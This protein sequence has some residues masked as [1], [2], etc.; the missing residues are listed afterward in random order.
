MKFTSTEISEK[1]FISNRDAT[2]TEGGEGGRA[3]RQWHMQILPRPF[4]PKAPPAGAYHPRRSI[5]YP[6]MK[7][8]SGTSSQKTPPCT[9]TQRYPP[10]PHGCCKH[11][12]FLRSFVFRNTDFY[13]WAWNQLLLK[14]PNFKHPSFTTLKLMKLLK[15]KTNHQSR[16]N[17]GYG[18]L[19]AGAL[20]WPRGMVWE[21]RWEGGSGW[22]TR[23]H[24][25][26]IHVDV[27]QN[28][29]N[30]VKLNKIKF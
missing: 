13:W 16:F 15:K 6:A 27:W 1:G 26:W 23:V 22:G 9:E 8:S 10:L 20:G 17:A 4:L 5:W 24:P 3:E 29:Y 7:W 28:Q 19:G 14:S 11:K 12:W 18:M 30:I 25:W 2:E 21:G